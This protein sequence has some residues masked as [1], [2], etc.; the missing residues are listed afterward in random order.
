MS[1]KKTA[2]SPKKVVKAKKKTASAEIVE[3]LMEL[4]MKRCEGDKDALF[5]LEIAREEFYRSAYKRFTMVLLE[6]AEQ[7][8]ERVR[9]GS[10][11]RVTSPDDYLQSIVD[12]TEKRR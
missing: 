3:L 10:V 2:V 9:N 4:A 8:G 7:H 6:I 12:G 5:A 11:G 1:T